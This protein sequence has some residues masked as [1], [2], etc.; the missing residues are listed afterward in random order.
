MTAVICLGFPLTTVEGKRGSSDDTLMDIKCP[1]IFVVGQNAS[2]VRTDELEDVRER[3]MVATSLVVVGTADDQLRVSTTKKISDGITQSMVD[4]C[5]LDEIGDF[6]GSILLQPHPLPLRLPIITHDD[7][8]PIKKDP[9]K[10]KSSVSSSIDGETGTS[11][12]KTRPGTPSSC[13]I[14]SQPIQLAAQSTLVAVG[15][16]SAVLTGGIA[17]NAGQQP[18]VQKRKPRAPNTQ[19][20]HFPENIVTSKH[21]TQVIN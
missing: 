5:I 19:K 15:G 12:K 13:S 8:R 21:V 18:P 7:A 6:I 1:V 4:R 17:S 16:G 14:V 9:R 2:L 20:N 3:M 11:V 10:R